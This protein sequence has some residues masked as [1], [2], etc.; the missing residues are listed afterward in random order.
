[1]SARNFGVWA[2]LCVF[3]YI[4]FQADLHAMN[5][6]VWQVLRIIFPSIFSVLFPQKNEPIFHIRLLFQIGRSY[7]TSKLKDYPQ[8]QAIAVAVRKSGFKVCTQM[9]LCYGTK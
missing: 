4:I 2:N 9:A 1:M 3:L 5:T 7:V 6:T 8:F